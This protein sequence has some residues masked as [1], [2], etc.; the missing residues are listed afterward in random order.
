KK[1]LGRENYDSWKFAMREAADL[2]GYVEGDT[3]YMTDTKKCMMARAKIIFVDKSNYGYIQQMITAKGEI[4]FI[5]A[6]TIKVKFLRE[7]R[8][9]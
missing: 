6:D 7:I 2:W 4:S 5:T 1:L 3:T 8:N 9:N